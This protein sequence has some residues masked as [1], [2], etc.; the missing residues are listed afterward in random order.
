MSAQVIPFIYHDKPVRSV[1][2]AGDPWFVGKDVCGVLDIRDH[3]QALERLDPDERGGCSVP[4]PSGMQE[5]VIISEPGV[6]RLVFTSRKPEAEAFKRWL[7]HEVL[8]ELRRRGAV[9]APPSPFAMVNDP[10]SEP[11]QA[12]R[13]KLDL[14]REARHLF[15][16]ERARAMWAT[17]GLPAVPS[18]AMSQPDHE[19]PLAVLDMVLKEEADHGLSIRQALVQAF[20]GDGRAAQLLER[21]G[22]KVLVEDDGFVLA[23][24]HTFVLSCFDYTGLAG[25]RWRRILR[26]L[27]GARPQS[28]LRIDGEYHRSVFIPAEHLAESEG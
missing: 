18:L 25:G 9:S 24:N 15:G 8:P 1:M 19:A 21:R 27:K 14:V 26:R 23:H 28:S 13:V 7:A 17:V 20:D 6:Y 5:M 12:Q 11:V 4:T 16:I 3:R 2:R 22:I 10:A